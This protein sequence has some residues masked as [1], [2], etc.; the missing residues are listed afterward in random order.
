MI[1][2]RDAG[3]VTVSAAHETLGVRG[4]GIA[5]VRLDDVLVPAADVLPAARAVREQV[6]WAAVRRATEGH[7]FAESFLFLTDRLG[8]TAPPS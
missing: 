2:P 5:S 7:P 8:I 6:D 1:V 4:I 3:G